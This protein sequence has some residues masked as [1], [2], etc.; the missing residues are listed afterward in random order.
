LTC[1]FSASTD[2]PQRAQVERHPAQQPRRRPHE[3]GHALGRRAG[4]QPGHPEGPGLREGLPAPRARLPGETLLLILLLGCVVSDISLLTVT[5]ADH[6]QA[7]R[8]RARLQE[9]PGHGAH[10]GGLRRGA[11]GDERVHRAEEARDAPAPALLQQ[12][13][14][15][16]G[17]TGHQAAVRSAGRQAGLRR[18]Y[19]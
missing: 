9:V 14:R 2:R 1:M 8:V 4:L 6:G 12:R 11:C 18:A 17:R 7:A 16:G 5:C 15:C 3:P 19:Q 13:P 10:A